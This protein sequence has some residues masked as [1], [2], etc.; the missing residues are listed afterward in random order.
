[1]KPSSKS[2]GKIFVCEKCGTQFDKYKSYW[3]HC[4]RKRGCGKKDNVTPPSPAI[5]NKTYQCDVCK[6]NFANSKLYWKHVNRKMACLSQDQCKEMAEENQL[7]KT[8]LSFYEE[9][10]ELQNQT[11]QQKE[12]EIELLRQQL[13]DKEQL[14][15]KLD[16]TSS[17]IENKLEL[18]HESIQDS[19]DKLFSGNGLVNNGT[20]NFVNNESNTLFN[21]TFSQP[22]KER[23]DHITNDMLLKILDHEN[24]NDSLK[25]MTASIY[26][27]PKA[28]ENWKWNVTDLNAQFGALDYNFESGT[29]IRK[30]TRDVIQKHMQNVWFSVT[31]LLEE[32]RKTRNMNRPQAINCSRLINMLGSRFS[33]DQINSMKESAYEGRQFPKTLWNRLDIRV[34]TTKVGGKHSLIKKI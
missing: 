7:T 18:V 23:L 17:K 31:D 26:F 20:I 13:I 9:K 10:T 14:M 24:V 2:T 5:N 15:T 29:L 27:H 22:R 3:D 4:Q 30:E 1:M 12:Q 28:P 32:L 21:V 34:E 8:R 11:L 33:N 6:M 25:D 19:K 16:E